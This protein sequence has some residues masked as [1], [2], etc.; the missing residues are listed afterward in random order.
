MNVVAHMQGDQYRADLSRPQ[1]RVSRSPVDR[2]ILSQFG[3]IV[4]SFSP[5][6]LRHTITETFFSKAVALVPGQQFFV[7]VLPAIVLFLHRQP[8]FTL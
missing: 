5:A 1:E 3:R 2:L 7:A 4:A 6:K 8:A